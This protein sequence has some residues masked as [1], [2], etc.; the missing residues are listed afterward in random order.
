M[1]VMMTPMIGVA[2]AQA[3]GYATGP[4][5]EFA[6]GSLDALTQFRTDMRIA[7]QNAMVAVETPA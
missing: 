6:D 3:A 2:P 7:G 1:S 4:V 5:S